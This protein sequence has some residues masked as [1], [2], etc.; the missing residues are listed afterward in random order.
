MGS[1]IF[2]GL[3]Y[4]TAGNIPLTLARGVSPAW[5]HP[6]PFLS[7]LGPPVAAERGLGWG[8]KSAVPT[9]RSPCYHSPKPSH[10]SLK[11]LTRPPSTRSS[12]PDH[13]TLPPPCYSGPVRAPAFRE[14]QTGAPRPGCK[15]S[16]WPLSVSRSTDRVTQDNGIDPKPF[17]RLRA[18]PRS[19]TPSGRPS[20]ATPGSAIIFRRIELRPWRTLVIQYLSRSQDLTRNRTLA[21]PPVYCQ[22]PPRNGR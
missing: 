16:P 7:A 15:S 18:I 19:R 10:T 12:L 3:H 9:G 11:S 1:G 6:G 8:K 4:T 14:R 17:W 22:K 20:W 13:L 21:G 2:P 5:S